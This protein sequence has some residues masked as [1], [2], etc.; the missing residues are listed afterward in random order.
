M[1]QPS[2]GQTFSGSCLRTH[3]TNPTS[4]I[5]P[6]STLFPCPRVFQFNTRGASEGCFRRRRES[7]LATCSSPSQVANLPLWAGITSGPQRTASLILHRG[8]PEL[9]GAGAVHTMKL[10][11]QRL[12]MLFTLLLLVGPSSRF[13]REPIGCKGRWSQLLPCSWSCTARSN[14]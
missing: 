12:F 4:V 13:I 3:S 11:R 14:A 6:P 8:R 2:P 9:Q 7:I 1:P 5:P 10:M